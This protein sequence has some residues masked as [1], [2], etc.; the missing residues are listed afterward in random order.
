MIFVP[1]V[2]VIG[3]SFFKP[4]FVNRYVIPVAIGELFAIVFAIEAIKNK[5]T[6][7]IFA[8]SAL[9]IVLVFNCWYPPYHAKLN[10]RNTLTQINTLLGKNDVILVDSPLVFF[11]SIYYS[12]DPSRVFLYNPH[13]GAFPWYVGDIIVSPSQIVFDLPLYPV[14]AFLVHEDGTFNVAYN[15]SVTYRPQAKKKK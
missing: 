12:T 14:R 3:I 13:R 15:T 2:I 5:T 10:I 7:M 11:E 8:A 1:L 9:A 6:Q 4:L